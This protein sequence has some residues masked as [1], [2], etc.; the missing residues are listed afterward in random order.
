MKLEMNKL[1][2]IETY[3]KHKSENRIDEFGFDNNDFIAMKRELD[4]N[5]SIIENIFVRKKLILN[6][7]KP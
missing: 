3:K 2:K 4:D 5:N 6:V 7:I 1:D